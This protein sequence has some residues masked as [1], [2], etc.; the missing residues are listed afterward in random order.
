MNPCKYTI[1]L[2]KLKLFLNPNSFLCIQ[3]ECS[4]SEE[5]ENDQT[6]PLAKTMLVFMVRGLISKLQFPYAQFPC[7]S[8]KGDQMFQPFWEA[9]RRLETVGLKVLAVTFDGAAPNRRLVKIHNLGLKK[10]GDA[11][12]VVNP[13]AV[14]ERYLYFISDPPHLIKTTRNGWAS[15]K[16]HLWVCYIVYKLV[17][18][19]E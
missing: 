3:L 1:Y 14:E 18:V 15:Q 9:V 19:N 12:R 4:L 5:E 11:Y 16:R 13:F 10:S 17:H 2:Q 8:L 6:E 7:R